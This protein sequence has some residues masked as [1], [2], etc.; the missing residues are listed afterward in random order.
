MNKS[1]ILYLL[2]AAGALAWL[3]FSF[4]GGEEQKIRR[5]LAEIEE[6]VEK[7]PGEGAL[8]GVGRARSFAALFTEPFDADVGPAG[9]RIGDRQQLMQVFIG[10]RHASERVA[11]DYRAI[12]IVLSPGEKEAVVRLEA[13]LNGGPAGLLADEHFPVELLFRKVDGDWLVARAKVE[14]G[15]RRGG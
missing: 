1:R 8:D 4:S 15:V 10:F 7:A 13:L 6:L 5:R 2:I 3:Y 9:Q 14:G 11:L 12:E